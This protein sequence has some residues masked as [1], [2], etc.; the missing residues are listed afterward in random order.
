MRDPKNKQQTLRV[1]ERKARPNQQTF[2]GDQE[3]TALI[4]GIE[5][6]GKRWNAVKQHVQSRTKEKILRKI[7]RVLKIYKG[8]TSTE[9][10]SV[11][12]IIEC[13]SAYQS[14]VKSVQ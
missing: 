8:Y 4:Q 13:L 10:A 9:K 11:S 2:W 7:R 3:L 6:H 12:E 14:S 1:K 5:K